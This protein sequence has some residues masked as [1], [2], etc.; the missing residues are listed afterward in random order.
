MKPGSPQ[1]R[2]HRRRAAIRHALFTKGPVRLTAGRIRPKKKF[3]ANERTVDL[4]NLP[5]ALCGLTIAH[6]SDLHV[7]ELLTPEHLPQIVETTNAIGADMIV[8][9]GDFIDFSNDVLPA[10][11][12]AMAQ[13]DAPLGCWFVLGNHDHLDNADDVRAAFDEAGLR[14]FDGDATHLEHRG[15]TIAIGGVDWSGNPKTLDPHIATACR[16]TAKADLK[17]LLAHHPHAFDTA[18]ETGVDLTLSGHTHGGQ[19]LLSTKRGRKGSI[20]LGNIGF[21]YTRGIYARGNSRL[22]VS[23]G[24]GAW[25]PLRFRCPAEITRLIL[26][27]PY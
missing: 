21:R 27:N 15:H 12:D 23:S 8:G 10:V 14:L 17:I 24:V 1:H 26:Q 9:T 19:I 25:F 13:L 22:H 2:R 5:D 16:A 18:Y 3:T 11:V 6:L 4:P 7:G 20:G